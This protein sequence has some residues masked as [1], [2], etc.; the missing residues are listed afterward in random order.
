MRVVSAVTYDPLY[1]E[2]TRRLNGRLD[3]L[4]FQRCAVA[5]LRQWNSGIT[6][7]EGVTDGGMDGAV[8]DGAAEP[9]PL[10]VTTAVDCRRN[11]VTNLRSY[12]RSGG[13]RRKVAFAT[14][15]I[16]DRTVRDRLQEKARG[17]GFVL[18]ATFDQP[19]FAE[20]LLS[21]PDWCRRLLDLDGRLPPLSVVPKSNRPDR[22][23]ALVGREADLG[24]LMETSEDSVLVG[25]PGAGK[26]FLLKQFARDGGGLFVVED[27]ESRILEGLRSQAPKALIVDDAHTNL[28]L[29]GTLCHLRQRTRRSFRIVASCWPGERDPVVAAITFSDCQ[30]RDLDLLPRD[31]ILDVIKLIGIHGPIPLLNELLTQAEG[32][33]GLA[34]TLAD[35]VIRT[36]TEEVATAKAL[37]RDI[38][39]SVEQE[40]GREALPMLAAFSVGGGS[41]IPLSR[42][43]SHLM[44]SEAEIR[45]SVARLAAAGV[46]VVR[47]AGILAVTPEPL[48]HA[49][50]REDLYGA[51]IGVDFS[52]LLASAPDW[53]S[54][55]NALI[56][57]RARGAP[58]PAELLRSRMSACGHSD[59]WRHFVL[60]GREEAEWVLSD[61]P[62]QFPVVAEWALL[63]APDKV[64]P[65]LLGRAVGDDRPTHSSPDHPLRILEDWI[66]RGYPGSDNALER[67]R[68]LFRSVVRWTDEGGAHDVA[69]RALCLTVSPLYEDSHMTPGSTLGVTLSCGLIS[70]GH[71]LYLD[72][73]WEK[74]FTAVRSLKARSWE[75]II[76][77]VG[78]WMY[79]RHGTYSAPKG[80]ARKMRAFARRMVLSMV[81]T[82]ASRPGLLRWIRSVSGNLRLG[83]KVVGH[84]EFETV[85]PISQ[86]RSA[87][88]VSK[89]DLARAQALIERWARDA[90]DAVVATLVEFDREASSVWRCWPSLLDYICGELANRTGEPAEW[91]T[92]LLA[93]DAS[94]H[95]IWRFV[96][97]LLQRPGEPAGRVIGQLLRRDETRQLAV[98][99]VLSSPSVSDGLFEVVCGYLDGL[100]EVVRDM[101]MLDQIS[102]TRVLRLLN[103]TDP[104][105]AAAAAEG[106]WLRRPEAHIRESL[107]HAWRSVA[108]RHFQQEIQLPR[109]LRADRDLARGWLEFKIANSPDVLWMNEPAV[110]A[111]TAVLDDADRVGLLASLPVRAMFS[112][113]VRRLVEGSPALYAR[114]L[115]LPKG[116]HLHL[117]PL[118]GHPDARWIELAQL[119]LT[120]GYSTTEVAYATHGG[121]HGW[122]GPISEY[123]ARRADAF[124]QLLEHQD[125]RIREVGKCAVREAEFRMTG[126][127]ERER[128]EAISGRSSS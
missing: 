49:L 23:I 46:V 50:I 119:A 89:R 87:H 115:K 82:A 45:G 123:W 42:V 51:G 10:V 16:L 127:L 22:G 56:G 18:V 120:V 30:V 53:E 65:T 97:K 103:H 110:N 60:L 61:H 29:L 2:I 41:G 125:D 79:A 74:V 114:L 9:Y 54:A 35:H 70:E 118:R 43:A 99:G 25:Q 107:N 57:A 14:S 38:K 86:R 31:Q 106:E 1:T 6:L 24:W 15:R 100:S 83:Q 34:A 81:P 52:E 90:H 109:I 93:R 84:E 19:Y 62:Q 68:E 4:A 40:I 8:P 58:V 48:R 116:K 39:K 96:I 105:I 124:R 5:L 85:F 32:R 67:R 102:E 88:G 37:Y 122:G 63:S 91:I 17:L 13:P 69:L 112:Q 98:Q 47:S 20:R 121:E 28:G 104:Q 92:A 27:A 72:E 3:G 101:C 95:L 80:L 117:A 36:G 73:L 126:E 7:V 33:P 26:S 71:I 64:I 108:I 75:P 94:P 21:S 78:H 77:T 113:L 59:T 76:S 12:I 55:T 66:K 111:A 44:K 128:Q 11:L